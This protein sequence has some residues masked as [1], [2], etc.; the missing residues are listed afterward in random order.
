M[1][2]KIS[3]KLKLL[4]LAL[5]AIA[6]FLPSLQNAVALELTY[7]TING[8][9]V[10]SGTNLFEFIRYVFIFFV[11]SAGALGVLSLVIAGIRILASAGNPGQITA[12]KEQITGSILGI[13]LLMTS[14]I[15]L[16]TIN[17]DIVAQDSSLSSIS[18]GSVWYAG[19][20]LPK[21]D[22]S[23]CGLWDGTSCWVYKQ[24]PESEART[25]NIPPPYTDL[26][27]HC[28]GEQTAK[29][30]VWLYG[31]I[32]FRISTWSDGVGVILPH[33]KTEVLS[34]GNSIPNIKSRYASFKWGYEQP[35]VYFFTNTDCGGI[36]S[37][38][39][40]SP[41]NIPPFDWQTNRDQR[42][43]SAF[44]KIGT[45]SRESYGFILSKNRDLGGRCSL[46][47]IKVPG[48]SGC[49][50]KV[51]L[52]ARLPIAIQ[53]AIEDIETFNARYAYIFN[54]DN[55]INLRQS[56]SVRLYSKDYVLRI[57]QRV[58]PD[59]WCASIG[60][61]QPTSI[62]GIGRLLNIPFPQRCLIP[63]KLVNGVNQ[64]GS[65]TRYTPVPYASPQEEAYAKGETGSS[66]FR[67]F[68]S[69]VF[70]VF[71]LGFVNFGGQG[72]G[73]QCRDSWYECI[74]K[75]EHNGLYYVAL[76]S[77]NPSTQDYSCSVT[78]FGI[79]NLAIEEP[80][81]IE[82][83]RVIYNMSIIPTVP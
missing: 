55:D 24:A 9:G 14:V 41:T 58:F 51:D 25:A 3:K 73:P 16:R 71:T 79:T 72:G 43:R 56:D 48:D 20:T 75:I 64:G 61:I 5:T 34:C 49:Y 21:P 57:P 76:Y 36:A 60:V 39:Q 18:G 78:S 38:V 8:I 83:G 4:F 40:K 59:L 2:Q 31:S 82:N 32:N 74:N 19:K 68:S 45:D 1:F 11:A 42:P 63:E 53:D 22:F 7:P 33:D 15:I 13:I 6:L 80:E 50:N 44:I 26:Y 81:I 47:K 46:P 29:L 70:R 66:W 23:N 30:M 17:P 12:A 77:Y 67:S 65:G 54:V 37:Q 27:Y 69:A 35:G 28:E 62:T 52:E 10:G